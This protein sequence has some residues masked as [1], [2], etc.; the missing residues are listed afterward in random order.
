MIFIV[1]EAGEMIR[2]CFPSCLCRLVQKCVC[3]IGKA[4]SATSG[5]LIVVN[6]THCLI[7]IN[8]VADA[9]QCDGK[10]V[11]LMFFV[12]K[13]RIQDSYGIRILAGFFFL[14]TLRKMPDGNYP[15]SANLLNE[16]SHIPPLN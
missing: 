8:L 11:Y 7:R 12:V 16:L 6:I 10:A 15:R 14:P 13:I 2:P 5:L 1:K 9:F 4:L 3:H